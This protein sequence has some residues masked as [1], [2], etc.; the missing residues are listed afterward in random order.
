MVRVHGTTSRPQIAASLDRPI[1]YGTE[2][3]K[4]NPPSVAQQAGEPGGGNNSREKQNIT[5]NN[6]RN[7]GKA[8]ADDTKV[9][10]HST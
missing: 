4:L 10:P 8:S 6:T 9:A 5:S 1:D 7:A 2:P 3:N